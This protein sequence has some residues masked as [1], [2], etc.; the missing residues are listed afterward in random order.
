[1]GE[2]VEFALPMALAFIHPMN[3]SEIEIVTGFSQKPRA[4]FVS[5]DVISSLQSGGVTGSGMMEDELSNMR[6]TYNLFGDIEAKTN[7]EEWSEP[8]GTSNVSGF[9]EGAVVRA[10]NLT[11][12]AMG[13]GDAEES[14][15]LWDAS[16]EKPA[17]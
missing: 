3:G 15:F 7:I 10:V 17:S 1:M 13:D 4:L 14:V 6:Y 5:S 12:F 8:Y 16:S 2:L 11:V 9:C